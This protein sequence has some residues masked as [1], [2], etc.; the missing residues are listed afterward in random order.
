MLIDSPSIATGADLM[1]PPVQ[2]DRHSSRNANHEATEY[3]RAM[4]VIRSSDNDS[5]A[6]EDARP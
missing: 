6:M 5:S 4:Q 2:P 3:S 1:E